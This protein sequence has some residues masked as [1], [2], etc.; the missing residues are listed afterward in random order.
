MGTSNF[1]WRNASECFAIIAKDY[2]NEDGDLLDE[3]EE[4]CETVDRTEDEIDFIKESL[5]ASG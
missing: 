5:K 4:G 1:S 2:Y 3:W